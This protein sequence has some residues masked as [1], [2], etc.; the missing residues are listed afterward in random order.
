M[1]AEGLPGRR[2]LILLRMRDHHRGVQVHRDQVSPARRGVPGQRPCPLPRGRPRGPDRLQRPRLVPAS[3]A[4]SRDTSGSDATGPA[5]AG[6]SRNTAISARRSPPSATA[7]ARSATIFPGPCAARGARHR[8][9]P[10]DKPRPRIHTCTVRLPKCQ[11]TVSTQCPLSNYAAR[12]QALDLG[13]QRSAIAGGSDGQST[14]RQSRG[15][16]PTIL[17]NQRVRGGHNE[18][19]DSRR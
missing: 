8:A 11:R 5:R 1:D 17:Q 6:C 16:V 7:A 12:K 19:G 4:T 3:A 18:V 10:S 9:R 14:R 2:G 13:R 15:L